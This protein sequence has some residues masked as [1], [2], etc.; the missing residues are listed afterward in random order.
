MI[1]AEMQLLHAP[2]RHADDE[3]GWKNEVEVTQ[4]LQQGVVGHDD[5]LSAGSVC[6]RG[7]YRLLSAIRRKHSPEIH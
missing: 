5:M 1:P 6:Y 3:K 4:F 7:C 2:P